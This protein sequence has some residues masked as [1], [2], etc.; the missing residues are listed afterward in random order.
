[1]FAALFF[2]DGG[3][4]NILWLWQGYWPDVGHEA[5]DTNTTTGSGFI[6]W[7]SERRAAMNTIN[8]Y[9]RLKYGRASRTMKLVWAGHEPAEFISMFPYWKVDEHVKAINEKVFHKLQ[10]LHILFFL[11]H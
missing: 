6:R 7:H 8:E 2:V 11:I 10:I 5:N 4:S 3:S 1:M 9:R